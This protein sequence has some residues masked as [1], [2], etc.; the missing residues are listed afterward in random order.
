MSAS[1]GSR[2]F[3][4]LREKRYLNIFEIGGLQGWPRQ[5]VQHLLNQQ[6]LTPAQIGKGFGDGMSQNSLQRIL[7]AALH[8]VNLLDDMPHDKWA[9]IPAK[10]SL[11]S[12]LYSL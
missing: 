12:C 1:R 10:G 4:L 9:E 3:Y 6:G 2:G 5:L 7:P 11:P 8:S